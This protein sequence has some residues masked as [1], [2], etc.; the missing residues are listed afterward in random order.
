MRLADRH[1]DKCTP[2]TPTLSEPEIAE[3]LR[4]LDGWQP[5]QSDGHALITKTF[6]F[7][8]FMPGV[9]LVNRIAALAESE[10]HHPDLKL[11]Y[12]SLIVDLTTHAAGGVTENDLILAAKID[13]D[14]APKS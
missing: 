5:A 1:C 12:G 8:G 2:E 10:G 6:R 11:T 4:Q 3:Q 7:K 9:D 13:E 14:Q